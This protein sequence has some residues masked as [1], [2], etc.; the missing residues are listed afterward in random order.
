MGVEEREITYKFELLD[1]WGSALYLN[2]E[3]GKLNYTG[4]GIVYTLPATVQVRVTASVAGISVVTDV[5]D[6]TIKPAKEE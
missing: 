1:D 4:T 2:E 6:I 3:T 5:A